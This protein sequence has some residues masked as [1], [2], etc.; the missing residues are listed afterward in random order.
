MSMSR[1]AA[2]AACTAGLVMALKVTRWTVLTLQRLAVLVER[3]QDV[4]GNGFAFA[5]RVGGEDQV[6]GGFHRVGD[7]FDPCFDG[8][9][10]DL[11]GHGEIVVRLHRTI[12][13]G[14][15]ADM[16]V[17]G[18]DLIV[19]AQIFVDCLGLSRGFDDDDVHSEIVLSGF[20]PGSGNAGRR[21]TGGAPHPCQREAG[22]SS[23]GAY[24]A[25]ELNFCG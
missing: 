3:F 4:P 25:R 8:L 20:G 15:V 14:Q 24:A 10:I 5:I 2:I 22:A 23:C 17:R 16:S 12:L 21:I 11:P 9:G 6:V 1:G 7:V 19:R 13:G 18:Q